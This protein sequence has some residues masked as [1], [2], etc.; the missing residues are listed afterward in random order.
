ML[1]QLK[2]QKVFYY[3]EEL[4][5]IPHGSGNTQAISDYCVNFAKEHSLRY[6]QDE[7][8]NVIIFKNSSPGYENSAPVIIQ[9]HLD[10]VCEREADCHIDFTKEGLALSVSEGYISAKGTTLGG[11][12]G[13]GVA[14]ALA[15][16]S[17]NSLSHPPLEVVLTVDEEIGMLGAAAINCSPL[18]GRTM[19]NLDSEDEGI[20]LVSCAGGVTATCHLPISR[21]PV[22]CPPEETKPWADEIYTLT[23][24]GLLGGHSGVE[25]NQG[26]ANANQVLGRLLYELSKEL[27]IRL[28]SMDGGLKDNAIPREGA[29]R[30]I[31]MNPLQK[32][33]PASANGEAA[34]KDSLA[35]ILNH[36]SDKWNSI[37]QHEYAKTDSGIQMSI[38]KDS[39]LPNTDMPLPL[40]KESTE[41]AITA[42]YNLPGGVIRMSRAIEG[43][44]QTSLN[45]G[46]LQTTK[47][48]ISYSF[49]VRSSVASEKEELLSRMECLMK[50][51]SGSLTTTGDYPAWE[52]REASPLCTL[53]TTVFEEQ[54]GYPPKIEAIHAGVECGLFAGKLPGLDCVSIGPEILDIH[55]PKEK[56]NIASCERTWRYVLEILKRLK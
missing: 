52:Y 45:M 56:L 54:Y 29:A 34:R 53:M 41:R 50:Q 35:D 38:K 21:E 8:H 9:G 14:F 12:D 51:L 46:I 19:L 25:I 2:P 18:Q 49:S 27:H 7:L 6:I 30:L 17:D 32:N 13:I 42:L 28:L 15:I 31:V 11:D 26:R 55:T 1:E 20:L 44:V 4:C 43:L 5:A 23:V 22:S 39:S 37:L 10:M 48:K 33:S 36:F 24:S 40:T 16:L 47:E 3:F